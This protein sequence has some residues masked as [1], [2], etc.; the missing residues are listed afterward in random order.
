MS[1]D[2]PASLKEAALYF[3]EFPKPGK[4]E[5]TA[6]KPLANTRDLALAYSPGV[7]TPCE[8]IAA[9]PDDVYRYT[10][11]GNLVA[12]ISNGTAVLGLGNIGALAS[13]P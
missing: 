9:N 4:L 13:K 1:E 3:H 6:T 2:K 5:I 7:A 8:E 11:K 10:S 12:V